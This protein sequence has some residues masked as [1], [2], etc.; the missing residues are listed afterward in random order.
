MKTIDIEILFKMVELAYK[1]AN[2]PYDN[3][4]EI[5]KFLYTNGLIDHYT[6]WNENKDLILAE[7]IGGKLTRQEIIAI[8]RW[9]DDGVIIAMFDHIS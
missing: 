5:D 4:S 7:K 1:I 6:K 3:T 2:S 8:M 9:A